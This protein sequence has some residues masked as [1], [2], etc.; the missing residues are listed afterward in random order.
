VDYLDY[1]KSLPETRQVKIKKRTSELVQEMNLATLREATNVTQ[2]E[3]ASK[4]GISQAAIS[5]LE[6][7]PD[8]LLSTLQKYIEAAGGAISMMISLPGMKFE[9]GSL[10]EAIKIFAKQPRLPTRII[11]CISSGAVQDYEVYEPALG[12]RRFF[13]KSNSSVGIDSGT[14]ETPLA[15]YLD[16]NAP[17]SAQA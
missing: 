15:D 12:G 8:M 7:R 4:L 17:N 13:V 10:D 14:V 16:V 3:I 11:S 6:K 9:F 1:L 2:R 5:K